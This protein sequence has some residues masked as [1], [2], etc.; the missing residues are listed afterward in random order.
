MYDY[1]KALNIAQFAKVEPILDLVSWSENYGWSNPSNPLICFYA[2]AQIEDRE[3]TIPAGAFYGYVEID[4]IGKAL[5]C[6]ADRPDDV[7]QFLDRLQLME[8][9]E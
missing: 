4:L 6:Y 3:F 1:D 7:V 8:E 9:G 2:I 5:S